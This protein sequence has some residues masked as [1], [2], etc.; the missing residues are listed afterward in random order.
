MKLEV[1]VAGRRFTVVFAEDARGIRPAEEFLASLAGD[2]RGVRDLA[3]I[4]RLLELFAENGRVNNR[5]QFKKLEGT[6]PTLVEFKKHQ[7]RVLGF[8]DGEGLLCLTHGFIKKQDRIPKSELERAYR[9][10]GE[11]LARSRRNE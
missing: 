3:T 4:Y 5:Q 10:R 9:I 8:F 6:S 1:A 11:H 2:P 7:V